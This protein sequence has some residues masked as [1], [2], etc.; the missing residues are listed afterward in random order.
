MDWILDANFIGDKRAFFFTFY[1]FTLNTHYA[2]FVKYS[3]C[4]LN[5]S[6]KMNKEEK[7]ELN[8]GMP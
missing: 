8:E 2:N 7:R 6:G 1:H 4:P 3:S 5:T